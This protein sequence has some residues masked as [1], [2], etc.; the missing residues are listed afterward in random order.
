MPKQSENLLMYNTK[1]D[2]RWH[3]KMKTWN[4]FICLIFDGRHQLTALRVRVLHIL[5]RRFTPISMFIS[6]AHLA[7]AGDTTNACYRYSRR[8]SSGGIPNPTTGEARPRATLHTSWVISLTASG[9]LILLLGRPL[10]SSSFKILIGE[11]MCLFPLHRWISTHFY[12]W[13]R[14]TSADM[15]CWYVIIALCYSTQ[16]LGREMPTHDDCVY[17]WIKLATQACIH[18]HGAPRHLRSCSEPDF[19]CWW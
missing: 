5:T 6:M 13:S 9:L 14:W 7:D 8:C 4:Y 15:G 12:S 17:W 2:M 19:T 10:I 1:S 18:Y 11:F 3:K 16:C